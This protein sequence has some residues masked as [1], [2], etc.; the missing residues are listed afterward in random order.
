MEAAN[1]RSEIADGKQ[2][3]TYT[4]SIKKVDYRVTLTLNADGDG[5]EDIKRK[6]RALL[7]AELRRQL[8]YRNN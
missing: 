4:N 1:L 7:E 5:A 8:N 6:L 3:I 2:K